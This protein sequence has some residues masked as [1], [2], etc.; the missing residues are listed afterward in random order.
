MMVVGHALSRYCE[1]P[2]AVVWCSD[3]R[4]S[5]VGALRLP[6]PSNKAGWSGTRL[7]ETLTAFKRA[8]A[9]GILSYFA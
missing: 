4:V 7:S 6:V 9:D 1:P 3:L 5:G 8:G 2:C